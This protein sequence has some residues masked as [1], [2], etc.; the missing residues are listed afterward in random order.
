MK[1]ECMTQE[2]WDAEQ[3]L[4]EELA[5]TPEELKEQYKRIGDHND[6]CSC[7]FCNPLV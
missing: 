7:Y 5:E 1:P 3:A 4:A 2:D 6:D